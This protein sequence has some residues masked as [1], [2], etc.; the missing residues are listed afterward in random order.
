MYNYST[1]TY[2]EKVLIW[3]ES[4]DVPVAVCCH[5]VIEVWIIEAGVILDLGTEIDVGAEP[6][7]H[8]GA[9]TDGEV[10]GDAHNTGSYMYMIV[11]K[12]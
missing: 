2:I 12:E 10:G 9:K 4:D 6:F 7:V 1:L 8:K 11:C 3:S 5:T